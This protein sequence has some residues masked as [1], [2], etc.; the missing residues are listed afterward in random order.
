MLALAGVVFKVH[1]IGR[2]PR[3]STTLYL[4]MGWLLLLAMEPIVDAIPT[5]GVVWLLAGGAF[6]TGGVWFY[7]RDDRVRFNHAIWHV[8]VLGGSACHYIAVLVSVLPQA[9]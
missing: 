9:R 2:Y 8:F 7:V 3:F 6:Y 5:A 1:C 4:A